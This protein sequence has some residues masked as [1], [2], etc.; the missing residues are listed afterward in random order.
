MLAQVLAWV[1]ANAWAPISAI[2]LALLVALFQR[3]RVLTRQITQL[4]KDLEDRRAI[5][6]TLNGQIVK[7]VSRLRH[8]VKNLDDRLRD[9][10]VQH[11]D[12]IRWTESNLG[13]V[14]PR[15]TVPFPWGDRRTITPS[16]KPLSVSF[17]PLD[18]EHDEDAAET[19]PEGTRKR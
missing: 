1:H 18:P 3:T 9:V 5:S 15:R 14:H 6:R 2:G 13:E 8:G 7:E 19:P 17:H 12:I 11:V 10:E 16:L 4:S